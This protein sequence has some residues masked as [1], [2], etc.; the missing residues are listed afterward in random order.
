LSDGQTSED[1]KTQDGWQVQKEQK[2][3]CK[4]DRGWEVG[5][6]R[7]SRQEVVLEIIDEVGEES[8][9][10]GKQHISVDPAT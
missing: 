10:G 4:H 3:C 7:A 5:G 6:E 9:R 8:A 1:R 2:G